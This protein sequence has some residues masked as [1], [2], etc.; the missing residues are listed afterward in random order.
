MEKAQEIKLTDGE[1][2]ALLK[3]RDEYRRAVS[4][5]AE[6][7]GVAEGAGVSVSDDC[8]TLIVSGRTE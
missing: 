2:I 6:L 4:M 7:R 1:R 5:I 8:G 3:R